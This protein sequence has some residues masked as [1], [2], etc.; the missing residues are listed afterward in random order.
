MMRKEPLPTV[1][2]HAR[3]NKRFRWIPIVIGSVT[4]LVVLIG[5]AISF[6]RAA[7]LQNNKP[8][9]AAN[10]QETTDPS[11]MDA[12]EAESKEMYRRFATE[13]REAEDRATA[14][15]AALADNHKQLRE[16]AEKEI[17]DEQ[18][19]FEYSPLSE[20]RQMRDSRE[21]QLTLRIE[22]ER[23]QLKD[24]INAEREELLKK[25][26]VELTKHLEKV[27]SVKAKLQKT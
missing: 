10:E 3:S 1:A 26:K 19:R 14:E 2:V 8:Q 6:W 25:R 16:V 9:K 24:R 27:Q 7:P 15:I 12:I 18:K 21:R 20:R 11:P 22:R 5:I 23:L 17:E 4:A 13:D